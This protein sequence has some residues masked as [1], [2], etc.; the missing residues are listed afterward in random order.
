MKLGFKPIPRHCRSI[1]RPGFG[2]A[3]T[4]RGQA[5]GL[6]AAGHVCRC[7]YRHYRQGH[8][9]RRAVDYC[10]RVGRS[11]RRNRRQTGRGDERCVEC[12]RQSVDLADC[13][14]SYDFARFAQNRAGDAYRIFVYR[15]FGRKRWA[16]VTV[17]LFPNCCWLPLPCQYRG[18]G[19]IIHPIMQSIASSYGSN[20]AKGT[21][22]KMGKYLALVNY[23][24][25]PISSA[26][27]ITATAPNPLIVN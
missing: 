20:P 19:G 11:N 16:S 24:S 21:E 25:N 23:H 17:S 2:T 1:V 6:D 18:G 8:A 26:M 13:H 22:R 12:V 15:R 10:R 7:D 9:V 4:R 27:F 3:R 5:S 14:R